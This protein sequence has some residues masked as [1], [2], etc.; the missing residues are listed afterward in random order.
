MSFSASY[1]RATFVI[2]TLCACLFTGIAAITGSLAIAALEAAVLLAAYAWSP[3]RYEI[4]DG[5][6][7]VYRLAGRVRI[8]LA[9][10]REIRLASAADFEGCVKL[11]GN[12]G[13]FGYYGYFRTSRL[14]KA[15]W[16]LTRRDKTVVVVTAGKPALFSP[17]DPERFLAALQASAAIP[18]TPASP[19]CESSSS[20]RGIAGMV[21]G[22]TVAL[23]AVA[24]VIA[25]FSYSPGPPSYTLTPAALAIHD[26]F[27]PVTV[28]RAAVDVAHIRLIDIGSDAAW[29]PVERT[30]GFANRHYRS[31]WFRAANGEKIR[32]YAADA[33]RLVLLPPKPGGVPVLLEVPDPDDFL[34]QLRAE[35]AGK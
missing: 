30:N 35:W 29:R 3:R 7:T 12:G 22:G 1:D 9:G 32:L 23:L 33:S 21:V 14:G 6:I 11:W 10:I 18:S 19:G 8:P 28:R 31:G 13:I 24:A 2:T 17:D 34:E 15:W 4:S 5:A 27:Y 20:P 25:A 26:R 16:Y